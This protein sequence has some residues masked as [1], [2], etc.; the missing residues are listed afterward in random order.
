VT[1]SRPQEINDLTSHSTS[2]IKL[3]RSRSVSTVNF[4]NCLTTKLQVGYSAASQY[5]LAYRGRKTSVKKSL[6][7]GNLTQ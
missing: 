4:T 6:Q 3:W 1:S 7:E 5:F 2:P